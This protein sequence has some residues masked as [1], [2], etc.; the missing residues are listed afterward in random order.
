MLRQS[1]ALADALLQS[2]HQRQAQYLAQETKQLAEQQRAQS[3]NSHKLAAQSKKASQ[4]AHQNAK[5]AQQRINSRT[6][7][8]R[9]Q[10]EALAQQIEAAN[11]DGAV[12][13]RQTLPTQNSQQ[14][15]R[16]QQ[17]TTNALL[18]RRFEVAAKS[19]DAVAKELDEWSSRINTALN[20]L[21]ER[22]EESLRNAMELLQMLEEEYQQTVEM[23]SEAGDMAQAQQQLRET[24]QNTLKELAN[25]LALSSLS[26]LADTLG[27][28]ADK[29][30][31]EATLKQAN[32]LLR[33]ELAKIR[34]NDQSR[35]P[36]YRFTTPPPAKYRVPVREYF[37]ELSK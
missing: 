22:S 32:S 8:L 11:P 25:Q 16:M 18:Y 4:D 12:A 28:N 1:L 31:I 14:L 34:R 9:Q 10:L 35:M 27:V 6:A 19:Q 26:Q 20:A 13:L 37:R 33:D 15:V 3:E 30:A 23:A 24:L 21:A 17:R 36:E 2:E 5:S 7:E 29:A